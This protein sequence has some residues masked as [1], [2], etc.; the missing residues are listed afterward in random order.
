MLA[1][2]SD[3]LSRNVEFHPMLFRQHLQSPYKEAESFD[4]VRPGRVMSAFR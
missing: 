2:L 4:K 3:L 1:I